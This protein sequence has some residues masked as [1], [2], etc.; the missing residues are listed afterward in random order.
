SARINE[1][2]WDE[3]TGFYYDHAI[4]GGLAK[5]K[6]HCGFLP[7]FAQVAPTERAERLLEHLQDESEFWTPLPVP[8]VSRDDATYS[9]DMWRGPTWLNYNYFI[10]EGLHNY[11]FAEAAN[12]LT[13]RTLNEVVRWYLKEGVIF[14][15]YD[16]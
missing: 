12:A 2:L 3:T 16:A 6:T 9:K 15:Y 5:L 14:E 4:D 13:E 11:G 1:L 10:I 8:S 7:L